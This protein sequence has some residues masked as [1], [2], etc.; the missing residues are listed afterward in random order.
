MVHVGR[1]INGDLVLTG[2]VMTPEEFERDVVPEIIKVCAGKCICKQPALRK[3]IAFNFEDNDIFP[4]A[5]AD[6]E[7]LIH[8]LLRES[9]DVYEGPAD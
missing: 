1:S 6:C 9:E 5:P 8:H 7:I 3:L 2:D 4:K